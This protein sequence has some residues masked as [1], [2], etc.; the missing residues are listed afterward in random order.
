MGH[1]QA[2]KARSHAR[3]LE[4][5]GQALRAQG[6]DAVGVAD[7][8]RAAGLTAGGFYKHFPTR[9]ALVE[10]AVG[11]TFGHWPGDATAADADYRALVA[12]YLSQAHRDAPATGCPFAAL[13]GDLARAAPGLRA[14]AAAAVEA[15]IDRFAHRLPGPAEAAHAQAVLTVCALVGAVSLA[16]IARDTPTSDDILE[17]VASRLDATAGD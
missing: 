9:E 4:V 13:A 11:A 1:T 2:E 12:A 3:I 14:R 8:M 15:M 16:R 7:V 10:E 6:L 5:A 17:T